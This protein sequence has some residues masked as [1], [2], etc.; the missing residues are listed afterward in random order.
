[1][2]TLPLDT[3]TI[4]YQERGQGRALILLHG[5]PITSRMWEAQLDGLSSTHRVI[6]PDYRGFGQ[7]PHAGPFTIQ[8]LAD[9]VHAIASAL[10]I[11]A[12]ILGGLSMGGYVALAYARRYAENLRGLILLDTKADADSPDA[13][14]NRNTMIQLATE[15]GSA[16]VADTMQPK[17]FAP[18]T[19]AHK[20]NIV[21]LYREMAESNPPIT[22]AHALAAMRDRPEQTGMLKSI[23]VPTLIVV[24]DGDAVT[25]PSVAESMWKEIPGA[26]IATIRGAGHMSPMEQPEQVNAAINR[27]LDDLK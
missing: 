23:H 14:Q 10:G 8:S 16:A 12:F 27:F 26:Q 13:K 5:F 22:L 11:K 21:K 3:T 1:M 4:H 20:P 19:L 24:G 2:P 7:S 17:L 9:D 25:P 15:K 6:A 18:D